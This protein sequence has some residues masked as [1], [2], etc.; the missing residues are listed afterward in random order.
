MR[1]FN[2]VQ[3]SLSFSVSE[4]LPMS[5]AELHFLGKHRA[6]HGRPYRRGKTR[7]GYCGAPIDSADDPDWLRRKRDRMMFEAFD[8][9]KV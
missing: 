2:Y 8:H 6:W 7:C 4:D 5:E 3:Y 1:P 9:A